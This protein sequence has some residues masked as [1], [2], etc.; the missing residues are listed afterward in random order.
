MNLG[1]QIGTRVTTGDNPVEY[2]IE[3][4]VA[5]ISRPL[6]SVSKLLRRNHRAMFDEGNSY[7]QN[8]STGKKTWLRDEGGLFFLDLIVEV[9]WDMPVN[10]RF[11][12]P[13][14]S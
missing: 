14:Q 3:F 2:S 8:K 13:V 7:I 4:D 6:G 9:P 5:K 12:R 11:V 1:T 10:P